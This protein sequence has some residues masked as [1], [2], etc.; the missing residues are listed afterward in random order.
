[1]GKLL[2]TLKTRMEDLALRRQAP[3]PDYLSDP[4]AAMEYIKKRNAV[5][6]EWALRISACSSPSDR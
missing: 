5:E 1:M 4:H 3:A 6:Y 2:E